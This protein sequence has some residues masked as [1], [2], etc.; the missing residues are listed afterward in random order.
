MRRNLGIASIVVA[1]CLV[2]LILLAETVIIT[3]SRL[4]S[5]TPTVSAS[6]DYAAGDAV[7]GL[8]TIA[9]AA[10]PEVGSGIVHTVTVANLA[11]VSTPLDVIIFSSNPT[12]TTVTDNAAL[13]IADADLPK[14][15]C[16]IQVSGSSSLADNYLSFTTGA[17]CVFKLAQQQTSLYAIAVARAAI[18]LDSTSDLTFRYGILQD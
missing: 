14:V 8:Q 18:N 11:A 12:G 15:A 9:G 4:I 17:N 2:P 7:G 1:L 3:K 5:V 10:M 16:V 6:P 13:D